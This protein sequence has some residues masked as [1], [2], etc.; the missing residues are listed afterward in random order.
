MERMIPLWRIKM[1]IPEQDIRQLYKYTVH[2]GADIVGEYSPGNDK[3]YISL[4]SLLDKYN[5]LIE[6]DEDLEDLG[7]IK[8]RYIELCGRLQNG[9]QNDDNNRNC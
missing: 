9:D 5:H 2:F 8:E 4:I 3:W 7:Y 6:D 1:D